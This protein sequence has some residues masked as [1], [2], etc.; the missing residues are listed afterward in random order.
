M[1]YILIDF[2]AE[3][4]L[5]IERFMAVLFVNSEKLVAFKYILEWLPNCMERVY[6]SVLCYH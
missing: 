1:I 2:L 6:N 4:Y 5:C 3:D